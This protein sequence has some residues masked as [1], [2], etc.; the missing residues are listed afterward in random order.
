MRLIAYP[1]YRIL[2]MKFEHS[3]QLAKV[4]EL[5]PSIAL[6]GVFDKQELLY[7]GSATCLRRRFKSHVRANKF[8]ETCIIKWNEYADTEAQRLFEDER[9]AISTLKPPMNKIKQGCTK[10]RKVWAL[11]GKKARD[12]SKFHQAVYDLL[13]ARIEA[14][15]SKIY[16]LDNIALETGLSYSWL[17]KFAQDNGGSPAVE[18]LEVL[19]GF[20]AGKKLEIKE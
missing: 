18:R 16:V 15:I 14:S 11:Y 17:E 7:I 3:M 20:L 5:P 2:G 10:K 19:Y 8:K 12:R 1:Q 6:Y 9:E 13:W 4:S